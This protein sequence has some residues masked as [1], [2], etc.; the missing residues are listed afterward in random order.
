[1]CTLRFLR[2]GDPQFAFARDGSSGFLG[3]ADQRRGLRSAH[4]TTSS[5][6]S[7]PRHFIVPIALPRRGMQWGVPVYMRHA[8]HLIVYFCKL[9]INPALAATARCTAVDGYFAAM[10]RGVESLA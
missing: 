2:S 10:R 6:V 7:R 4:S 1:M 9:D 8:A 3:P 5:G